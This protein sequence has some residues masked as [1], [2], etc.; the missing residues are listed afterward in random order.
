MTTFKPRSSPLIS[1]EESCRRVPDILDRIPPCP[2]PR[3]SLNM[4]P[5]PSPVS[6]PASEIISSPTDQVNSVKLIVG[7]ALWQRKNVL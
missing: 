5:H 3:P 4:T 6:P 7:F 1:P 2:A